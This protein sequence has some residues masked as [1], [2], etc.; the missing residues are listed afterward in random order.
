ME[1][2]DTFGKDTTEVVDRPDRPKLICF[3][4]EAAARLDRL[5]SDVD[6]TNVVATGA[7]G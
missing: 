5:C 6:S 2:L 1:V 4:E 3:E 7:T